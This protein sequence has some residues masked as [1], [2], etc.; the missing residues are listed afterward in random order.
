MTGTDKGRGPSRRQLLGGILLGGGTAASV[1]WVY[2]PEGEDTPDEDDPLTAVVEREVEHRTRLH[3]EYEPLA[4]SFSYATVSESI[5]EPAESIERIEAAP[6]EGEDGDRLVFRLAEG[7]TVANVEL[8]VA[9]WSEPGDSYEYETSLAGETVSF[10][11]YRGEVVTVGTAVRDSD[12]HEGVELL[13][14]RGADKS[15]T[16]QA[17]DDFEAAL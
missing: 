15:A 4:P 11:V 8:L 16:E 14:A 5:E 2:W 6:L 13:V 12:S 9:Y 10:E 7:A 1:A 17:I 3:D